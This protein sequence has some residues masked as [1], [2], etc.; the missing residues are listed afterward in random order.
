MVPATV[1]MIAT[2]FPAAWRLRRGTDDY[3]RIR[4]HR[5][6]LEQAAGARW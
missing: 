1:L 6:N 4:L 3:R 2:G 5:D